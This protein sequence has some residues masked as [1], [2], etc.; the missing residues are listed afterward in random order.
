MALGLDITRP[1]HVYFEKIVPRLFPP[2]QCPHVLA[3]GEVEV[4]GV[5]WRG[6]G[7][8]LEGVCL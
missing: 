2:L 7:G 5:E 3:L 4:T 8:V 1:S 6:G